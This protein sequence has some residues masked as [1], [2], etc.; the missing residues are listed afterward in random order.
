MTTELTVDQAL[1]TLYNATRKALLTLDE[2]DLN[3]ACVDVLAQALKLNVKWGPPQ[4]VQPEPEEVKE[5]PIEPVEEQKDEKF[6][7]IKQPKGQRKGKV[8]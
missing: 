2:H 7:G 3:R 6:I 5:E 8:I 1:T 4:P